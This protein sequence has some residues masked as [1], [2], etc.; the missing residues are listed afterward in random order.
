MDS[1]STNTIKR[2]AIKSDLDVTVVSVRYRRAPEQP[3]PAA[4]DDGFAAWTWLLSSS[5]E[6]GVDGHGSGS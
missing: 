6:L 3:F 4:L 5:F 2:V 1:M